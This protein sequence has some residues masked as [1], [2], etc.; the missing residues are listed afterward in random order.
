M[1]ENPE[2]TASEGAPQPE[3]TPAAPAGPAPASPPPHAPGPAPPPEGAPPPAG[4]PTPAAPPPGS[5]ARPAPPRAP[6]ERGLS[7]LAIAGCL[8]LYVVAAGWNSWR[9]DFWLSEEPRFAEIARAMERS[10]DWIVPKLAGSPYID[11]PPLL[12]WLAAGSHALLGGDPRLAYRLPVAAAAALGLLLTYVLGRRLFDARIAFAGAAIQASTYAFF[13]GSSWFDDDLVFS[14]FLELAVVGFALATRVRSYRGWSTLGWLGLAGCALSKSALLAFV[15]VAIALVPFL[16][17][18]AGL[19]GLSLGY[20]RAL[21]S[22]GPFAFLALVVP[23]YAAV[24]AREGLTFLQA[25]VLGQHV[26]RL[27]SS[28]YDAQPPYYYFV[29]IA[30]GFLPWTLFAPLGLLHGKDRW[31]R[32]GERLCSF[33]FLSAFIALSLVSGK[34]AGYILVVWPALSLL[35]SAALAETREWYSLWEGYLKKAGF[36]AAPALMKAPLFLVLIGA[37]AWFSGSAPQLLGEVADRALAERGSISWALAQAAAVSALAF[38]MV[39]R[40]R[41]L[42][43]WA[44]YPEAAVEFACA[45]LLLLFGTTFFHE[46]RNLVHSSRPALEAFAAAIPPGAPV[47]VYGRK[48]PETFYYLDRSD[49]A[50]VHLEYP[51]VW[52]PDDARFQRIERFVRDEREAFIVTSRKEFERL[53]AQFPSLRPLLH[54]RGEGR[55]PGGCDYVLVSNRKAP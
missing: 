6:A 7:S 40:V 41:R 39:P 22:S 36:R 25:H 44:A 15:L 53:V 50:P 12:P 48:A 27:V 55:T 33:W 51:D 31:K 23:W 35:V 10:G 46:P 54:L 28:P 38:A 16:F 17:Y 20:R 52:K 21:R 34:R 19:R 26:A 14:V 9:R 18:E 24:T 13:A 47:A 11:L 43:S 2:R 45:S 30:L 42:A 32:D 3:G 1:D 29:A 37:A 49:P 8:L 4:A 5:R